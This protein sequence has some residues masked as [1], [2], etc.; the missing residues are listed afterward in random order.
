[1]AYSTTAN[2]SEVE[3]S[4]VGDHG[5]NLEVCGQGPWIYGPI[6]LTYSAV[7][8]ACIE[9]VVIGHGLPYK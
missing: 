4:S 5:E 9:M 6:L 2:L 7:L 3:E 8:Q 1:M